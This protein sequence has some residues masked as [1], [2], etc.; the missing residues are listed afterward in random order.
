MELR[1]NTASREPIY[2]QLV[3]QIREGIARGRLKPEQKLPSVRE[4]SRSLVV[5]PNTI[6]RVYTELER[7]AVLHARPGK[8]VFVATPSTE[9][10]KTA[11][12]KQLTELLDAFLTEAFYLGFAKHEVIAAVTDRTEQ[13]QWSHE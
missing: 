5:N 3:R 2:R 6:A 12:Q 10:T 11:R 1:I 4:L 8:G 9:L 7:E 13:F